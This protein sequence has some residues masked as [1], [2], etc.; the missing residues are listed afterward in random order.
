M[1]RTIEQDRAR[2]AWAAVEA[3]EAR[4]EVMKKYVP[5]V[6]GAPVAI[7]TAG[8]GQTIAFYLSRKP[9]KNPEYESLL[10]HLATWVLRGRSTDVADATKRPS[11]LMQAIQSGTSDDYR[12]LTAETLAYLAWLKRFAAAKAP[13]DATD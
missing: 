4:R 9:D 1:P 6:Q 8:L 5:L 2:A 10:T 13:A 3:V 7:H 12:R 11:D